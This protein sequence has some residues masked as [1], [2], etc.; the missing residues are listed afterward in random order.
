MYLKA[1]RQIFNVFHKIEII[2]GQIDITSDVI[3]C[4][5]DFGI[6]EMLLK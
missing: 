5:N 6:P 2:K 4:I 1:E 3:T